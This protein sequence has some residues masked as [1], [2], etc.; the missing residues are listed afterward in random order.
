MEYEDAENVDNHVIISCS[1]DL[2]KKR[3]HI[4]HNFIYFY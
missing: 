2:K 1:N 3:L 4:Y